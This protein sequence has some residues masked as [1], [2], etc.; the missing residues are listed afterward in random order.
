MELVTD[1]YFPDG[2]G[3]PYP[4]ILLRT[5]YNKKLLKEYGRFYS[6]HGYAV[7]IQD[8]RGRF[9]SEGEWEPFLNEGKDGYD[10]VE[11]I[12]EQD[13]CTGKVGMIGGSYS[14]TAQ[15]A[16]AIRKPPHLVTII[17][18]ITP[19]TPFDNMPYDRGALLLGWAVRWVDVIEN[20]HTGGEM[21]ARLQAAVHK[22]WTA[23]LSEL[24][25]IDLDHKIV[26]GETGYWRR[27]LQHNKLD[28]YWQPAEYLQALPE[29]NIPVFLQTGWFDGG[30][31][32]TRLAYDRLARGGNRAVRVV[33]G[34]WVHSDRGTRYLNGTDM[35]PAAEVDLFEQY[36][37]W[38][39]RLLKGKENEED[40]P[41][42]VSLYLMGSNRWLH[43]DTYPLRGTSFRP[44]YLNPPTDTT[45]DR[46]NGNLDLEPFAGMGSDY[47]AF[48]YDP[49]DPTPS[50]YDHIKRNALDIYQSN[51]LSRGDVLLYET[52]AL[53]HPL[54]IAGPLQAILYAASSARD[55]D[56]KVTLYGISA[57]GEPYPI[58]LTFGILRAR[59]RNSFNEPELLEP[60]RIYEYRLDIGQ[61]GIT[62][63]AGHRL[64]L[65]IA[66][67][68]FPEYSRNLNTGGNN[69]LESHFVTADQRIY[70]SAEFRSHIL[71]PVIDPSN[72]PEIPLLRQK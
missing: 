38:F 54:H 28:A 46:I 48:R 6:D 69:E 1:L 42:S 40:D 67:A 59:F 64:R 35:G 63:P 14:G 19:A 25:V 26:G 20:A 21:A 53:E 23:A 51:I 39:D 34:P 52:H 50:F 4:A 36:L 47:D 15:F 43:S 29:L 9:A 37:R 55:T 10:A 32:G 11:W 31:R 22:D 5:P 18:N 17:P 8:V 60:G 61:T 70:R 16:A 66:S 30:S 41:P 44:L 45:T 33:I 13:W 56:W 58:G 65:E 2:S 71:L 7:A 57:E 62:I 68:S 27:W 49:G 24:P 12:A 3:G 72:F